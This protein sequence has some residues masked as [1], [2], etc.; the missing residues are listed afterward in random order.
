M[1]K[2]HPVTREAWV[3]RVDLDDIFRDAKPIGDGSEWTVPGF[4]ESDAEFLVWL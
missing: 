4:F 2:P 3:D 1:S